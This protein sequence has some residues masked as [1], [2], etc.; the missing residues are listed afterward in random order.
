M[1]IPAASIDLA[2]WNSGE[3]RVA[4]YTIPIKHVALMESERTDT[5]IIPAIR[6]DRMTSWL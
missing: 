6:F 2:S 5:D 4:N 3:P 1:K